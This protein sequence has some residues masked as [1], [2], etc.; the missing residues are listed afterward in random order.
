[1]FDGKIKQRNVSSSGK[2]KEIEREQFLARTRKQRED[3]NADRNRIK[4]VTKLQS[5]IRGFLCRKSFFGELNTEYSKKITSINQLSALFKT[6]G[7]KFYVPIDVITTLLRG[8]EF[9]NSQLNYD[10]DLI[11]LIEIYSASYTSNDMKFNL[12]SK[13]LSD[14]RNQILN[15]QHQTI[16]I[17]E[18][19][20]YLYLKYPL[21]FQG[22]FSLLKGLF[23]ALLLPLTELGYS[24]SALLQLARQGCARI[25]TKVTF[26]YLLRVLLLTFNSTE[27][28]KELIEIISQVL[29]LGLSPIEDSLDIDLQ[30]SKILG[31][32]P[33]DL[34]V[35]S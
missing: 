10:I 34:A 19:G 22:C 20:L 14:D 5:C 6:R 13:V 33:Q 8:A 28:H 2:K 32:E 12:I 15:W 21:K 17:L 27:E 9:L 24:L 7:S 31:L 29:V 11:N 23:A 18:I 35:R 30:D 4:C 16:F 1:M 26:S 3:R 25:L